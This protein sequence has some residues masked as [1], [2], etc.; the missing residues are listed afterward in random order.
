MNVKTMALERAL[1][2]L[3][4]LGMQYIVKDAEGAVHS[5]GDMRLEV[6]PPPKAK[7]TRKPRRNL[8]HLYLPYLEKLAVGEVAVIPPAGGYTTDDFQGTVTAWCGHKWGKGS[9]M[10]HQTPAGL[11]ILRIA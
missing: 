11:E 7:I 4:A 6:A 5:Y 10:S 3:R 2:T 8:H 1:A 9:Y